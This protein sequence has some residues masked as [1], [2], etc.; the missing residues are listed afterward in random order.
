MTSD[1]LGF[2]IPFLVIVGIASVI[3]G[4]I[5]FIMRLRAG[6]P[7][8]VSLSFLLT[9]YVYLATIVG[10]LVFVNGLALL[11]N[12]GLSAPLGKEFSYQA[13]PIF[14]AKP[15]MIDT[16]TGRQQEP[17]EPTAEEQKAQRARQLQQ[18]YQR[19][20]INGVI[21]LVFG[22][23]VLVVH[24]IIRGRLQQGTAFKET[25]LHRAYLIVLLVT[26]GIG[27]IITLPQGTFEAVSYYVVGPGDEFTFFN[28]PGPKLSTAIVFTPIW[29]YYLFT[30]FRTVRRQP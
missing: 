28:P 1:I 29:I 19:G 4:I 27:S 6:E 11:L 8:T 25:L 26:F 24:T 22:A 13:Q 15:P 10:L 7:V 2:I 30:T 5:Y 9:A 12:A 3:G 18:A 23:L 20:I 17:Q 14:R 16:A 21:N